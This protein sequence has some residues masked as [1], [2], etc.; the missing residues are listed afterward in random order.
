MIQPAVSLVNRTPSS[1]ALASPESIM[2]G[3]ALELKSVHGQAVIPDV[4]KLH[5]NGA[6][7]TLPLRSI[8]PSTR[9]RVDGARC[10]V[11]P[12]E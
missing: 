2:V 10:P 12:T 5:E 3:V 11:A 9:R 4:V 6:L 1:T 8:A 7:M